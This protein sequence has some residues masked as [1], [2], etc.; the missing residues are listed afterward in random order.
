MF[1]GYG[2]ST[3]G[4]PIPGEAWYMPD[5]NNTCNFTSNG[6]LY[7]VKPDKS[8]PVGQRT[9]AQSGCRMDFDPTTNPKTGNFG[10]PTS[11]ANYDPTVRGWYIATKASKKANWD[12]PYVFDQKNG[13][14]LGITAALPLYSN[15]VDGGEFLGVAAAD[16]ELSSIDTTLAAD[17]KGT[18]DTTTIFIVDNK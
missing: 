1:A 7:A 16:Y 6:V 17:V 14:H 12:G 3:A 15:G 2:L 5:R 18:E 11:A 13:A 10:R 8:V 4:Y 9:K